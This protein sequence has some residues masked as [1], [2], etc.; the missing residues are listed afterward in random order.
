MVS[1]YLKWQIGLGIFSVLCRAS[2]LS[3]G[4]YPRVSATRRW[5]DVFFMLST[6]CFVWWAA[7]CL[8]N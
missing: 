7:S 4:K 5:E 6:L 1:T 3:W 2:F 8:P